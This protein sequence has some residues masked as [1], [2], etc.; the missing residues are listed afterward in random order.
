MLPRSG[1]FY[2]AFYRWTLLTTARPA[3]PRPLRRNLATTARHRQADGE[4]HPRIRR[5]SVH[6]RLGVQNLDDP[7]PNKTAPGATTAPPQIT[8]RP[9]IR[10]QYHAPKAIFGDSD[11]QPP[12]Q[13][14]VRK[15]LE[16]EAWRHRAVQT[17]GER[18]F[19]SLQAWQ[20]IVR[21]RSSSGIMLEV[22]VPEQ[23]AAELV[24]KYGGERLP[25]LNQ[26]TGGRSEL[27][28][29][30]KT[31]GGEVV[32]SLLVSGNLDEAAQV[33]Q[34]L[35]VMN[36]GGAVEEA[37]EKIPE[38]QRNSDRTPRT[39][40]PTTR[41]TL[42]G[43]RAQA[44]SSGPTT[45]GLTARQV[46]KPATANP[47]PPAPPL[48]KLQIRTQTEDHMT[49]E[50]VAPADRIAA[51]ER[52]Y[53]LGLKGLTVE[54]YAGAQV[55]LL[56]E[57][58]DPQ[59]GRVVSV[60][61]SGVPRAVKRVNNAL[62]M[63]RNS[64]PASPDSGAEVEVVAEGSVGRVVV[65]EKEVPRAVVEKKV[66][67]AEVARETLVPAKRPRLR[68]P[69]LIAAPVSATP[70]HLLPTW[71]FAIRSR[72]AGTVL[73]ELVVP[74][75]RLVGLRTIFGPDL[76]D[77]THNG[78][79]AVSLSFS[80]KRTY[81]GLSVVSLLLHGPLAR[82]QRV[83]GALYAV[84]SFPT[85]QKSVVRAVANGFS[86]V[87]SILTPRPWHY[88][89]RATDDS[90]MTV[91]FVVPK[92]RLP[93]LRVIYGPTFKT[94]P[95]RRFAGL[96]VS[97]PAECGDA[98]APR[99]NDDSDESDA[100]HAVSLFIRGPHVPLLEFCAMLEELQAE[101]EFLLRVT[102]AEKSAGRL[103]AMIQRL[104]G[105]EVQG[106]AAL[107]SRD[108]A[109]GQL[110]LRARGQEDSLEVEIAVLAGWWAPRSAGGAQRRQRVLC[111]VVHGL[112][113]VKTGELWV[114][115]PGDAGAEAAG[116]KLRAV[117]LGG[118]R[119][120]VARTMCMIDDW[121]AR[122]RQELL[123]GSQAHTITQATSNAEAAG[124]AAGSRPSDRKWE[125]P[126]LMVNFARMHVR[127]SR[128]V[129]SRLIKPGRFVLRSR[130]S[131]G[132]IIGVE[133][134]LNRLSHQAFV[135]HGGVAQLRERMGPAI[136]RVDILEPVAR[137][138]R[139]PRSLMVEGEVEAVTQAAKLV[140]QWCFTT[141]RREDEGE[142]NE[143]GEDGGR[144]DGDTGAATRALREEVAE[145]AR[146]DARLAAGDEIMT[147][148]DYF[149]AASM[150]DRWA[151]AD[152]DEAGTT[153]GR[154]A[155][156]N[157]LADAG[158]TSVDPDL[159]PEDLDTGHH[160][161]GLF[162]TTSPDG[163]LDFDT[164]SGTGG[165]YVRSDREEHVSL[166]S[167]VRGG[168]VADRPAGGGRAG[169]SLRAAATDIPR[170]VHDG[171][172]G[173]ADVQAPDDASGRPT[174]SDIRT[175]SAVQNRTRPSPA[176]T[177]LMRP[178][179]AMRSVAAW[180]LVGSR[181]AEKEPT[182]DTTA[183]TD[184]ARTQLADDMRAAS[185]PLSHPIVV[186]TS[187]VPPPPRRSGG[188]RASGPPNVKEIWF[189]RL[190]QSRG[191]T[192]SSFTTV[193]LHPVPVIAFN[194]K[195]PSRTWDAISASRRMSVHI[196]DATPEAAAIAHLF[197]LPHDRPEYPFLALVNTGH[198]VVVNAVAPPRIRSD[199]GA[200]LARLGGK[201]L[202]EKCVHVGDHVVVIVEV[203]SVNFTGSAPNP[204]R[205]RAQERLGEGM[206]LT[207]AKRQYRGVGPKIEAPIL[208]SDVE[209]RSYS[210][211]EWL[212][213]ERLRDIKLFGDVDIETGVADDSSCESE[214][215]WRRVAAAEEDDYD[216][217]FLTP[218]TEQRERELED[219]TD[220]PPKPSTVPPARTGT[221]GLLKGKSQQ[222]RPYSTMRRRGDATDG[223]EPHPHSQHPANA[224]VPI[225]QATPEVDR[226]MDS[227]VAGSTLAEFLGERAVFR[228][229]GRMQALV[230][231]RRH[232]EF[233]TRE[234]EQAHAQGQLTPERSL[235]LARTIAANKRGI[236]RTLGLRAA[237]E[238]GDMLDSGKVDVRR[239]QWLEST[240]ERGLVIA[241][242]DMR[243]IRA[244]LDEGK[245]EDAQFAELSAK[246]VEVHGIMHRE[247]MRLQQMVGEDEEGYMQDQGQ[248]QPPDT[249]GSDRHS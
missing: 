66:D 190:V 99:G 71:S 189:D 117:T 2:A 238:L 214:V 26:E 129:P 49:A 227:S 182:A 32:R 111:H 148:D 40:S 158:S 156:T 81:A 199:T 212:E 174:D 145:Q 168:P 175:A 220:Q 179:M 231:A 135:A 137:V 70:S 237:Y 170:I 112:S 73:L 51:F 50:I 22:C 121:Q 16:S 31:E 147:P 139:Q 141:Q 224:A 64:E 247:A 7:A 208:P 85:F 153:D 8:Q 27:G 116:K 173:S 115:R 151:N 89:I 72:T 86:D 103:E 47:P 140:V 201:L 202:A 124:G 241:V 204:E 157:S 249:D 83:Y 91:E 34:M 98:S 62:E 210:A 191:V 12:R 246:L 222:G 63:W 193:T 236:A 78:N 43:P 118:T 162:P 18:P 38:P 15:P 60:M 59:H 169:E 150:E 14:D 108:I 30:V 126:G 10:R 131:N 44:S 23:T 194:L 171:S 114:V 20:E 239:S 94:L 226:G 13:D 218:P 80:P 123:V 233:A 65:E 230:T 53:G 109:V 35:R 167:G 183:I 176:G 132:R 46:R 164:A 39:A 68:P 242:E 188:P 209:D 28:S 36:G 54:I 57:R 106:R 17:S 4:L 102:E 180:R 136:T 195:L 75:S 197:T 107:S 219:A 232:A 110:A 84:E 42:S 177:M 181:R 58:P 198:T 92:K 211:A 24:D 101:D 88:A 11:A 223:V 5:T 97:I 125:D 6:P 228:R 225:G 229:R 248:P 48:W 152:V 1:Q 160:D 93:G 217:G 205:A 113:R 155:P 243:K 154:K 9:L 144:E 37:T 221:K 119:V 90:A 56:P 105:A 235:E 79:G 33:M 104:A 159:P 207:Y 3:R 128:Q 165:T 52:V 67:T 186:V 74:V 184:A 69:E 149:A 45:T 216:M 41:W 120:A 100:A 29:L 96:E 146:D 178:T 166:A 77:L 142:S 76:R 138:R 245:I 185:R 25:R 206:G 122:Y 200:V 234:L 172:D 215:L 196:M 21:Y 95:S 161:S 240:V 187:R 87:H 82:V 61:L 163:S 192:V 143:A 203:V 134:T 127:T 244:L 19:R 133:T 55:T 213:L 130:S